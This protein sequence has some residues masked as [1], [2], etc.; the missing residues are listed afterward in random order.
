VEDGSYW[1]KT[2][3]VEDDCLKNSWE[4]AILN[5]ENLGSISRPIKKDGRKQ[6]L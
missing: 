3:E 2:K 5:N 6:R 1:V 4:N